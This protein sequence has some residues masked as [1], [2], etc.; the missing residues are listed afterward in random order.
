MKKENYIEKNFRK[1]WIR[2]S[3]IIEKTKRTENGIDPGDNDQY[4]QGSGS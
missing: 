1:V 2:P 3:L 4:I